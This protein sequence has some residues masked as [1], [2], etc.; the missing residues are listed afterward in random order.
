MRELI[1]DLFAGGGGASLGIEQALGLPV[2]L[3][4]N[5]DPEA[6]CMHLYNHPDTR[7]ACED[8]WQVDPVAATEG[9]PVGLLWASPDCT[10][11]S[12]AK[13]GKPVEKKKRSLAWAV[14]KWARAIHPRV[15]ILENVP[16]FK[17]WGPLRRRRPTKQ[18][19]KGTD[20]H[21]G[22]WEYY[23]DP[24]KKGMTYNFWCNQLRGLGYTLESR[25][26]RAC[27]YGAPTIRKRL[28]VIARCDGEPIRWP[29]PTHGAPGNPLGLPACR[30]AAECI[31]WSIPCPSIFLSK[32]EGKKLGVHR[33]L[34]EKTMARI[35][36]GIKKFVLETADPFIIKFRQG[37]TGQPLGTV[38]ASGKHAV[39]ASYLTKLYGTTTGQ[40]AR[41]PMAT[42]TGGGQHIAEVMAFLTKYYAPAVGQSLAES[43]HTA[44]AKARFGLV[45][46]HGQDY[47]IVDIGLRMLTPRELARAQGFPDSYY[48][49][50][51]KST[52]VAK[53]G[54]SVCPPI[55]KALTAANVKIKQIAKAKVS[56]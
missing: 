2:D 33:P 41:S 10:H 8:V 51:S 42:V 56:A 49:T 12:R 17:T 11:F 23:P 6:V 14:V 47:Q 24:A 16:E 52:Q 36:R 44:T 31:D 7:H 3:A 1:V 27:D 5:H 37:A 32:E 30:T 21:V 35:A 18:R 25:E 9:R 46:V 38:V 43:L 39:V 34:A 28:F 26:L 50:G 4:V 55:A 45:A 54:N 29:S 40:D 22:V 20:V 15:I 13:G 53:I 48:L 19:Y